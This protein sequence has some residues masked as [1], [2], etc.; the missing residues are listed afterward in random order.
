MPNYRRLAQVRRRQVPKQIVR[1]D[2]FHYGLNVNDH[3]SHLVPGELAEAVNVMILE[4]G[5]IRTREPV[6]KYTNTKLPAPVETHELCIIGNNSVEMVATNER[7]IY[8]LDI[9]QDPSLIP[10]P[11]D[12]PFFNKINFISYNGVAVILDGGYV[13][14]IDESMTIKLAYDD[15][16][17]PTGYQFN[18][19][20]L[21]DNNGILLGDGTNTRV[22]SKFTTEM[23]D[24]GYTIPPTFF[25]VILSKVGAPTGMVSFKV[26]K[27]S[28]DS[29][30][31]E[32]N[33]VDAS[34]LPD[35][36]DIFEGPLTATEEL[37]L[38]TEYYFSVEYDGGDATNHVTVRCNMETGN[39][40]AF[41]Y[42]GSAWAA[43][44]D[45]TPLMSAQPGLP[46]MGAWGD[47]HQG[48]LFIG[49]GAD[50]LGILSFSNMT[51]LDWSTPNG[52]GKIGV[53]DN[54]KN[55]FPVGGIIEQYN[56]LWIFGR[57]AQPFIAKL[58]GGS[59][60]EYVITRTMQKGWTTDRV[61]ASS[62]NDIWFSEA[63]GVNHLTGVQQYGDI[64]YH[65]AS[66]PVRPRFLKWDPETTIAGVNPYTGHYLVA[67]KDNWRVLVCH[68]RN[69]REM[70]GGGIRYPF[71]EFIFTR[72]LLTDAGQL[73]W[74]ES[75]NGEHEWYCMTAD[76]GDPELPRP[77]YIINYE[78]EVPEGFIGNLSE[79]TWAYGDND[80]LGFNTI[81]F[82]IGSQNLLKNG[83][84]FEKWTKSPS[85]IVN[86]DMFES[87]FLDKTADELIFDGTQNTN[88]SQ[89]RDDLS[90]N[91]QYTWSI[92]LRLKTTSGPFNPANILLSAFGDVVEHTIVFLGQK[93]TTDYQRFDITF[94]TTDT[95]TSV[96]YKLRADVAVDIIAFG[97]FLNKGGAPGPYMGNPMTMGGEIRQVAV[98]TSFSEYDGK[99]FMGTNEGHIYKFNDDIYK[100][101]EQWQLYV[102]VR[103]PY[104]QIPFSH[105]NLSEFQMDMMSQTG[106]I[107]KVLLYK[108]YHIKGHELLF[109]MPAQDDLLVDDLARVYVRDCWFTI[110]PGA[111]W[112]QRT[113]NINARAYQIRLTNAMLTG[114]PIY[115][116]GFQ[117]MTR[118]LER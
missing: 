32:G 55:N 92:Y 84:S 67:F 56:T 45:K 100:E 89:T 73:K 19:L 71:T 96:T 22:A 69:P 99:F 54:S 4:S 18:D 29:V 14:Y 102:D 86:P 75:E 105:V 60:Q 50:S 91:T 62:V 10:A 103:T 15:G 83:E 13:K 108:D 52:G 93:I 36:P 98:P 43:V 41:K 107:V 115:I 37:T 104:F 7:R 9:N 76:G 23:W 28:D 24:D 6:E 68:T 82:K 59:P 39:D 66:E 101:L 26:R 85:L 81:Y 97:A 114:K 31:A 61:L 95:P 116:N 47:I 106:G 33:I 79:F 5:K 11:G 57:R 30:I 1:H 40:K 21:A 109:S 34:V 42:D 64:R 70:P 25:Q 65:Y 78:Y 80:N 51:H 112:L 63:D 58:T 17:G 3:P 117:L 113:I 110:D 111:T 94:V 20:G 2:K 38:G 27:V 46:P 90:P 74:I 53:L 8:S 118:M 44:T 16:T 88:I 77:D 49:G 72:A 35:T 87:P 12:N 48:R